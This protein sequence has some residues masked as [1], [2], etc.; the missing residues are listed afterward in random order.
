MLWFADAT[1]STKNCAPGHLPDRNG[2]RRRQRR[3]SGSSLNCS[4][5]QIHKFTHYQDVHILHPLDLVS[6]SPTP[7]PPL[8]PF[9]LP[10][11]VECTAVRSERKSSSENSLHSN[12]EDN[13]TKEMWDL[14]ISA[15]WLFRTIKLN[16]IS[17]R[18]DGTA[19]LPPL[20]SAALEDVPEETVLPEPKEPNCCI[21]HPVH[22][23]CP[24]KRTIIRDL[25]WPEAMKARQSNK[26]RRNQPTQIVLISIGLH[27]ITIKSAASSTHPV[28]GWC[29]L[30]G[31]DRDNSKEVE[32]RLNFFR[33]A[34]HPS[35]QQKVPKTSFVAIHIQVQC[36]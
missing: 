13:I 35:T 30:A 14:I 5:F 31:Y 3:K 19:P 29:P 2:A 20:P 15:V 25:C 6:Q 17:H 4:R 12:V 22:F 11:S 16:W 33:L 1:R 24:A 21:A 26:R 10:K 32:E 28:K 9:Y 23:Y 8:P 7:P 18:A 36:T 34:R 27:F